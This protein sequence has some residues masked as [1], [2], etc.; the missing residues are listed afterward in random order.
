MQENPEWIK[1]GK[2]PDGGWSTFAADGDNQVR[3]V[4]EDVASVNAIADDLK[5]L[6]SCVE[7]HVDKFPVP[8]HMTAMIERIRTAMDE[9]P[10]FI[11]KKETK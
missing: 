6:L 2:S 3:Y 1:V 5:Y 7:T 10:E 9:S 11:S 8:S 4:R